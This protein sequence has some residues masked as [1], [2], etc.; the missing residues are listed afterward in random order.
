MNYIYFDMFMNKNVSEIWYDRIIT[1]TTNIEKSSEIEKDLCT[2]VH[3]CRY[4]NA[5]TRFEY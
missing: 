2:T 4:S 5:E 3:R 1:Y